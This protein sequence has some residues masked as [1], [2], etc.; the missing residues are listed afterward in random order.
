MFFKCIYINVWNC[1]AYIFYI[2]VSHNFDNVNNFVSTFSATKK[3][4]KEKLITSKL[5]LFTRSLEEGRTRLETQTKITRKWD[6][7]ITKYE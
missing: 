2:W 1:V 5:I 6:K 7:I 3:N 4:L